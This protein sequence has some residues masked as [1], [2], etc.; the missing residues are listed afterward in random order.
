MLPVNSG[1]SVS[2]EESSYDYTSAET[3]QPRITAIPS[4]PAKHTLKSGLISVPTTTL[5]TIN[6]AAKPVHKRKRKFLWKIVGFSA[7]NKSC[8]GGT[9]S[10]IVRCVR[11][12]PLRVF[13]PKKCSHLSKALLNENVVRC[14]T[15]ACPG[16]WKINEWS[17]C[18]CENNNVIEYQ[19]R[20][21]KCVQELGT[22]LVMQVPNGACSDEIPATKEKCDCS[23]S[24]LM[25]NYKYKTSN[26][27]VT[28]IKHRVYG[29]SKNSLS[30]NSSSRRI[31]QDAAW[32]ENNG[33]WLASKWNGQCSNSCGTG[34]EYRSIFCD[35]SAPNIDRCKSTLTPDTTR[36]CTNLLKCNN[37]DWFAGSWGSCSGDC[38][39]LTQTRLVYCIQNNII[40]NEEH[41]DLN[42]KPDR[43]QACSPNNLDYCKPK[44][45]YSEWTAVCICTIN[46][47]IFGSECF[48]FFS[49][50]V[51]QILWR[52]NA[53]ANC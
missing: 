19:H 53:K 20:E 28:S 10:P 38:F 4:I 2:S 36:P 37:G 46:S 25:D 35:R 51:F 33:I 24:N 42:L 16:Y 11:E 21:T 47:I 49:V 17:K 27:V 39:N 18:S 41:C 23:K 22:G 15:Q 14:N 1:P 52:G 30:P 34:I 32:V 48:C 13:L 29:T 12:A 40:I 3:E 31:Q 26:N 9:Q 44:W 6:T 8:G 45:L 5:G 7:C 50:L 43:L